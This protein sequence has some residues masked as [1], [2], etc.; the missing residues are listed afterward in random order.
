[1]LVA[2]LLVTCAWSVSSIRSNSIDF[3]AELD[4]VRS[5]SIGNR[6]IIYR[7]SNKANI[8]FLENDW[9]RQCVQKTA[10]AWR[11]H[12]AKLLK[13]DNDT[14]GDDVIN[15]ALDKLWTASDEAKL[16]KNPTA[17]DS[18][19]KK[20]QGFA[21]NIQ[22]NLG[23]NLERAV[24]FCKRD[25][26]RV[27]GSAVQK[28]INRFAANGQAVRPNFF[29]QG[30]QTVQ[31]SSGR[32]GPRD[33]LL[34]DCAKKV[35]EAQA[36]LKIW[37]KLVHGDFKHYQEVRE[38]CETQ[39]KNDAEGREQLADHSFN[40]KWA[41]TYCTQKC[42]KVETDKPT[43]IRDRLITK[44]KAELNDP[45]VKKDKTCQT[46]PHALCPEGTRPNPEGKCACVHQPCIRK[47][48]TS[49]CELAAAHPHP[50]F[51]SVPYPGL[52]CI[53]VEDQCILMPCNERDLA[54]SAY[55]LNDTN[56]TEYHGTF[57]QQSSDGLVGGKIGQYNCLSE[58]GTRQSSLDLMR[59]ITDP[60]AEG[61]QSYSSPMARG[62]LYDHLVL[63]E[64]VAPETE[65]PATDAPTVTEAP[66]VTDA[67]TE[68]PGDDFGLT[69][70]N[71]TPSS[72]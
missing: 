43:R 7:A 12:L 34:V 38:G 35:V 69:F 46:F 50:A 29:M 24:R 22:I 44:L 64:Y 11:A 55:H 45:V 71:P 2:L 9:D 1:M 59:I 14:M 10:W 58:K 19:K 70:D 28:C 27:D 4:V 57:G 32:G 52:K 68:R 37:C 25:D 31:A 54:K 51:G 18:A 53:S 65:A 67:P 60:R 15:K 8:K 63:G 13:D 23:L 20:V 56:H 61:F 30:F 42:E 16:L 33:A 36:D 41:R 62:V 5:F 48:S 40:Y 6:S 17:K 47:A 26:K 66:T 21:Q 39:K 3:S 49:T 72:P